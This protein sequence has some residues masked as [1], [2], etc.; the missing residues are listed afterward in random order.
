MLAG[1]AGGGRAPDQAGCV[2]VT[3]GG[4]ATVFFVT[5]AGGTSACGYTYAGKPA[6][7]SLTYPP[8]METCAVPWPSPDGQYALTGFTVIDT[9][10]GRAA[11]QVSDDVADYVWASDSRR[12]CGVLSGPASPV[13]LVIAGLGGRPA[14]VTLAPVFTRVRYSGINLLACDPRHARAVLQASY[15]QVSA[16][17]V[18]NLADGAVLAE[19]D[20]PG[21]DSPFPAPRQTDGHRGHPV[22]GRTLPGGAARGP[23]GTRPAG[24]GLFASGGD[25]AGPALGVAF[26]SWAADPRLPR[27]IRRRTPRPAG[28]PPDRRADRGLLRRRRPAGRTGT[29]GQG[30]ELT[31]VVR[32]AS[33]QI[34]WQRGQALAGEA[35]SPGVPAIAIETHRPGASSGQV[36]LVRPDGRTVAVADGQLAGS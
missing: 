3:A 4:Q 24:P 12:L 30:S 11:V 13:V 18:V 2:H 23:A 25:R 6:G 21:T 17:A 15:Q 29:R 33:R 34:I 22:R 14:Q 1:C 32:W 8:C 20:F 28:R 19:E 35:T 5:P 36:V 26:R 9:A 16:I 10:S 31:R 27:H 7:R